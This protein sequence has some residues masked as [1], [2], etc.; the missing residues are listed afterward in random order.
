MTQFPYKGD[1]P[2]PTFFHFAGLGLTIGACP[3]SA[4]SSLAYFAQMFEGTPL[5][6]PP[7]EAICIIREPLSRLASS[8][9]VIPEEVRKA[10]NGERYVG[11]PSI[12]EVIDGVL[13]GYANEVY[14]NAPAGHDWAWQPQSELFEC[15]AEPTW[16]RLDDLDTLGGI[17]FPHINQTLEAK[18]E[19]VHR[20]DEIR[21]YYAKDT[22]LWQRAAS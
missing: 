11:R 6:E 7:R 5:H 3:R 18:P 19:I 2:I 12:E 15:I 9:F 21:D 8:L 20:L 17:P 4:S 16:L 1:H 14:H 22:E 10:A 13:G